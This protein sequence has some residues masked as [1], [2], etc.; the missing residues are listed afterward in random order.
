MSLHAEI[1]D[2]LATFA[3]ADAM[4]DDAIPNNDQQVEHDEEDENADHHIANDLVGVI[5]EPRE[6]TLED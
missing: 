2:G 1:N 6:R 5:V 4:H 3:V